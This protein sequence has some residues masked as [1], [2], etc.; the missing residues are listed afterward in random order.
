MQGPLDSRARPA[1]RL[2]AFQPASVGGVASS[3][4]ALPPLARRI[5][6]TLQDV[7]F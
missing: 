5:G 3:T 4:A 1:Y 6:V 2:M 7:L